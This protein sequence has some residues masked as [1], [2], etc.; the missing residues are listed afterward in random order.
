MSLKVENGKIFG[1][2][3]ADGLKVPAVGK[4]RCFIDLEPMKIAITFYVLDCNV[5][6]ILGI[7]FL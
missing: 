6:C 3:L 7:L 2:Q 4:M 1:V 5:P